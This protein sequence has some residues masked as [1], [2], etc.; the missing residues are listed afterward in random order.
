[1]TPDELKGVQVQF[2]HPWSGELAKA[3]DGAVSEFN[4]TNIWGIS[5]S[6]ESRGSI[7]GID[8][9]IG[10]TAAGSLRPQVIAIPP[11]YIAGY[12]GVTPL[13]VYLQD[14]QWGFT[15]QE[16]ADFYPSFWNEGQVAA[17]RLSIPL[18]RSMAVLFYN[19]GWAKELGFTQSPST[20]A[21][22]KT[23]ICAAGKA[24]AVTGNPD[25]NGTGGW[26]VNTSSSTV[27]SW[28]E[29]YGAVPALSPNDP[30][31]YNNNNADTAFTYLRKLSDAS[32]AWVSRNQAPYIYFGGRQAL[33]FSGT[34]ED[35]PP[36]S[37][38]MTYQKNSDGWTVL[39]Y[40][41]DN[42]QKTLITFGSSLAILKST[43][44]QQ[45]AAWLFVRWMELPRVQARLAA[46][47]SELPVRKSALELMADFA[48]A[49]SQWAIAA[50]WLI[51]KT[52]PLPV[53][54]WWKVTQRVLEDGAGQVFQ[55]FLTVDKVPDVLKELDA[56]VAELMNKK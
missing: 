55:P 44:Q 33:L 48:K 39:P 40:P 2:W 53:Q 18:L 13:D 54:S 1:M 32:C 8:D 50:G 52:L 17:P 12:E 4:G 36:L 56:T 35:L 19:Q 24:V 45:L 11:E 37:A 23:Q 20:P 25:T 26:I 42:P 28:L 41:T 10:S 21:E 49:N 30:Q 15:S 7:L 34:L 3:I 46:A 16:E 31:L 9:A 5:V 14:P 51:G 47:G 6:A 38:A 43:P 22:F 29:A 27:Y